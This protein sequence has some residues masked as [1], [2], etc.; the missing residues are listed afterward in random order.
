MA[1]TSTLQSQALEE[2]GRF[3][4]MQIPPDE[5]D[6]DDDDYEE[7]YNDD[8]DHDAAMELYTGEN[9]RRVSKSL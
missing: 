2:F 1:F 7:D 3:E 5:D 8:D 6:D 4:A 9:P